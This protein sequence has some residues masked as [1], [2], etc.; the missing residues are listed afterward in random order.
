MRHRR[1]FLQSLGPSSSSSDEC[2]GCEKLASSHKGCDAAAPLCRAPLCRANH[3]GRTAGGL[4]PLLRKPT[5]QQCG[6]SPAP[7]HRQ[8]HLEDG[9]S[10]P[11]EI[12]K[13]CQR[14]GEL[15]LSNT[16]YNKSSFGMQN[17]PNSVT[18]QECTHFDETTWAPRCCPPSFSSKVRTAR[19][20]SIFFPMAP[21][22]ILW[23]GPK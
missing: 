21:S 6:T 14:S 3:H 7:T 18:F 4:T 17:S 22:R 13:T 19:T 16:S 15:T 2:I 5:P 11:P 12:G 8:S 10:L 1:R 23:C 20:P 9:C